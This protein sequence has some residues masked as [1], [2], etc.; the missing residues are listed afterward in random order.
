MEEYHALID[1]LHTISCSGSV[2]RFQSMVADTL[3]PNA[4]GRANA[5]RQI[6]LSQ[7]CEECHTLGGKKLKKSI[8][9]LGMLAALLLLYVSAFG[10]SNNAHVFHKRSNREAVKIV[11]TLVTRGKR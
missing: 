8:S 6:R 11:A 7:L 9:F 10:T 5:K 2:F 4:R 1:T 3:K